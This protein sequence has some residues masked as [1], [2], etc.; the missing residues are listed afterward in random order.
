MAPEALSLFQ[1]AWSRF[2]LD[3]PAALVSGIRHAIGLV[4][5]VPRCAELYGAFGIQSLK[6][7]SGKKGSGS[8]QMQNARGRLSTGPANWETSPECHPLER[9]LPIL[10]PGAN[11]QFVR[12]CQQLVTKCGFQSSGTAFICVLPHAAGSA[13]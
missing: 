4:P 2:L 8:T 12:S 7:H 3:G 13:R 6:L 5:P 10:L 11:R 1:V 9:T